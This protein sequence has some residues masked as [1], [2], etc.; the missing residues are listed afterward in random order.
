MPTS[1]QGEY[2]R[3]IQ[4]LDQAIRLNPR[5]AA[6]YNSRGRVYAAKGN[7]DQARKDLHKALELG[8]YNRATVEPLLARLRQEHERRERAEAAERERERRE[9]ANAELRQE[10]ERQGILGRLWSAFKRN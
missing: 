4:D 10:R 2:D 9:Q 1:A 8:G 5:F 3:A 7:Y 6:A